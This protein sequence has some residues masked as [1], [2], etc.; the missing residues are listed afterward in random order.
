MRGCRCRRSASRAGWPNGP[1]MWRCSRRESR[2]ARSASRRRPSRASPSTSASQVTTRC[3]A[4]RSSGCALAPRHSRRR[5]A[6]WSRGATLPARMP[7][8]KASSTQ[9]PQISTRCATGR[10]WPLCRRQPGSSRAD[11]ASMCS[12][13]V[14]ATRSRTISSTSHRLAARPSFSSTVP[15]ASASTRC[16][17]RAPAMSCLPSASRRTRAPQSKPSRTAQRV[18]SAWSPSPTVRC[19]LSPREREPCLPC[20]RRRHR[21][22]T[23]WPQRSRLR[24]RSRR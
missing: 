12:E 2:H 20:R 24:R 3:E 9:Y 21:F 16:A 6:G 18:A 17:V 7:W 22:S 15:A 8:R 19:P 1:T 11:A 4:C 5:P 13:A 10:R 14:R 23:R